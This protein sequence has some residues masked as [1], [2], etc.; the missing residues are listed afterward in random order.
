MHIYSP[1]PID[2]ERAKKDV[3]YFAEKYLDVTLTEMQKEI[4]ETF[5]KGHGRALNGGHRCG[6]YSAAQVAAAWG[7]HKGLTVERRFEVIDV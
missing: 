4:I 2:R 3:V 6:R 1:E 7:A 5:F